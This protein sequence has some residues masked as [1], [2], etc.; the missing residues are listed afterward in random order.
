M[1]GKILF[2]EEQTFVGTWT[3]YLLLA[4]AALSVVPGLI[5]LATQEEAQ[6][7][8]ISGGIALTIMSVVILL[9]ATMRLQVTVDSS[10]VYYRFPPFVSKERML[11]KI[12]IQTLNVRKYRPLWEYGGYGYRFRFSS[13]RA[14]NVAGKHGLQ[15]VLSNGKR[16]LIGTQKPEELERAIAQL[17]ENWTTTEDHV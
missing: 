2:E 5:L 14:I 12:D 17:K 15:L 10:A 8:L 6:S 4:I 3:W 11:G 9:Q 1:K 16:L 7:G 13:G